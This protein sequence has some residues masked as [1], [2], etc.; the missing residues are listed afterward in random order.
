MLVA[1]LQLTAAVNLRLSR[2]RARATGGINGGE[3]SDEIAQ[4]TGRAPSFGTIYAALDR[5][6]SKGYLKSK[7]GEKTAERGG[8]RKLNFLVTARG[9]A[10]LRHALQT[11]DALRAGTDFAGAL[12]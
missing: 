5:L 7:E 11:L 9:Q 4:Q 10:A 3:R 12:R 2:R 6:S 8:R 1:R